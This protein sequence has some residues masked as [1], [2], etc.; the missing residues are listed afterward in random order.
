V[1]ALRLSSGKQSGRPR[2]NPRDCGESFGIA[3]TTVE[4]GRVAVERGFG[5]R[6]SLV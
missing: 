4:N 1:D 5:N 3:I 2:T 6:W